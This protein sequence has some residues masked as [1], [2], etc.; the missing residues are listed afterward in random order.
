MSRYVMQPLQPLIIML[1]LCYLLIWKK[2]R[3]LHNMV[4]IAAHGEN[5]STFW[6][7]T[8]SDFGSSNIACQLALE[9]SLLSHLVKIALNLVRKHFL[10][11]S[12]ALSFV[13]SGC[14]LI[15]LSLTILSMVICSRLSMIH[16]LV[17]VDT[18]T[19]A[20]R[21]PEMFHHFLLGPCWR[22]Y[23]RHC[24]RCHWAAIYGYMAPAIHHCVLII[25]IVTK[26]C[27][28]WLQGNISR[29][30]CFQEE[31]RNFVSYYYAFLLLLRDIQWCVMVSK[32]SIHLNKI[33]VW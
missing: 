2:Q 27:L 17:D 13:R 28:Q 10:I 23:M 9:I 6:S 8:H 21:F 14:S 31:S 4:K 30:W 20:T 26:R 19:D 12:I 3:W 24:L 16:L 1:V 5:K 29:S 7:H 32:H 25:P 15:I 18:M 22:R 11:S 33:K